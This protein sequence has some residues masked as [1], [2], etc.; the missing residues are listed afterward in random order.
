MD[1]GFPKRSLTGSR[2]GTR[3]GRF[4]LTTVVESPSGEEENEED[5]E[6][7]RESDWT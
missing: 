3:E 1:A 2:E 5:V 7:S 6:E 4:P